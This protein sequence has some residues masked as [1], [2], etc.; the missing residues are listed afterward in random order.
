MPVKCFYW[1]EI[2]KRQ[3]A[4]VEIVFILISKYIQ[5]LM[6]WNKNKTRIEDIME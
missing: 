2:G 6:I 5:I 3:T 4:E 1:V